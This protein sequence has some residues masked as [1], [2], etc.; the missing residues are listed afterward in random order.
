[1]TEGWMDRLEDARE[2]GGELEAEE[3]AGVGT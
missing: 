3:M 2:A 1:M